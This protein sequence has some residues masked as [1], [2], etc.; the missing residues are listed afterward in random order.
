VSQSRFSNGERRTAVVG[1]GGSSSTPAVRRPRNRSGFGAYRGVDLGLP[2]MVDFAI[3]AKDLRVPSAEF[4]PA[5]VELG[6]LSVVLVVCAS[7]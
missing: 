1:R 3:V 4:E 5:G 7:H 2:V 6:R